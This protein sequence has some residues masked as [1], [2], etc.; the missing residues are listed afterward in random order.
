MIAVMNEIFTFIKILALIQCIIVLLLIFFA[1][2]TKIYQY[3][4][5]IHTKKIQQKITQIITHAITNLEPCLNKLIPYKNQVILLISVIQELDESM[6][7]HNATWLDL[8]IKIADLILLPQT[9]K[10]VHKKNWLQR[11]HYCQTLQIHKEKIDE[12]YLKILIQDP[13]PLIAINAAKLALTVNSQ[14]LIDATIEFFSEKRRVQQSFYTEITT[15][16]NPDLAPLIINKLLKSKNPYI[17]ACCYRMLSNIP[18]QNQQF[19]R[20]E[21]DLNSKNIDLALAVLS[22][23]QNYK[24]EN[25]ANTLIS[26]VKDNRWEVRAR[27]AKI[28]GETHQTIYVTHLQQYLSDEVWWVRMN[29]AEALTNMGSTGSHILRTQTTDRFATDAASLVLAKIE[30]KL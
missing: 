13:I 18:I 19:I 22:Y 3:Y 23:Y 15:D 14:A 16:L 27:I 7:S 6:H 8:R 11:Y 20:I 17:K 5:L 10:F 21:N 24:Y 9:R 25:L 30:H 28:M 12:Q 4:Q 29:A 26:M 1:Y 2:G